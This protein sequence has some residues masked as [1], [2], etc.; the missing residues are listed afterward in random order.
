MDLNDFDVEYV[1]LPEPDTTQ[2]DKHGRLKVFPELPITLEEDE[3]NS[4]VSSSS[5]TFVDHRGFLEPLASRRGSFQ[6][7]EDEEF[8]P[9]SSNSLTIT[10]IVDAI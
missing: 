8:A 6:D 5:I 2:S 1:E 7:E 3:S 4:A 10:E 9:L